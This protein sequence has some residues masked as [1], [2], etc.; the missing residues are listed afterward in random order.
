M[1]QLEMISIELMREILII[2]I[3]LLQPYQ[4]GQVLEQVLT[5]QE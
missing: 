2:R 1:H 5:N 3:D 4:D